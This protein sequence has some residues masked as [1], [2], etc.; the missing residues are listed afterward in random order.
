MEMNEKS[1][2]VERTKNVEDA[3]HNGDAGAQTELGFRY[4]FGHDGLPEDHVKAVEWYRK[5]AEQGLAGAQGCLAGMY[6]SGHGVP[7]DDAEAFK[8]LLKSADGGS[9]N[10]QLSL[11]DYYL[12]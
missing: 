10:S 4:H 1:W 12:K 3:A 9:Y 5:A 7:Q 2:G 6:E 11:A 8:W